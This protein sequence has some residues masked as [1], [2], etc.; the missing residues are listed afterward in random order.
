MRPFSP[1]G[2]SFL[3]KSQVRDT[4]TVMLLLPGPRPK[5]REIVGVPGAGDRSKQPFEQDDPDLYLRTVCET[6]AGIVISG[7]KFETGAP[8]AH[9]AFVKPTVGNWVAQ[10]RDYAVAC[11]VPLN[12]PGVRHICRMP[13]TASSGLDA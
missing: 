10:N 12:S 3:T 5:F 8:Y 6:D 9:V 1:A 7:A 11:I 13:L 4:R 2:D